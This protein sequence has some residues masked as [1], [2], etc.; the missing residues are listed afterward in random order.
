M[1]CARIG[2]IGKNTIN[3]AVCYSDG[4][5]VSSKTIPTQRRGILLPRPVQQRIEAFDR[6]FRQGAAGP[7]IDFSRPAGEPAL[8]TPESISWLVFKNPAAV[9]IGGVA[10][11]ILEL[12]EPRVRTGVWKHTSFRTAPL[13][14]L[15]R[16]GLAAMMTVYGPRR[17][18]EAMIAG[19]GRRHSAIVGTTLDG[20]RYRADDPELLTWVHATASFG[21]LEAYHVFARPVGLIDRDRYYAEGQDAARLYGAIGA[22]ASQ[23]AVDA[24]FEAMRPQ[25]EASPIVFEFLAI[26]QR[27][28][29]LPSP[30]RPI[31]R[32]FVKAA[33]EIT[34]AWLRERLGLD[35]RWHPRPWEKRLVA[36]ACQAAD[37]LVVRSSPAVQSCRR[38]GLPDDYLYRR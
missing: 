3:R 6:S 5:T 2:P 4:V 1:A 38:L 11:V 22:P 34:P 31:Q 13:E 10:A 23:A 35:E 18:A 7:A 16:T 26:M 21:F 27:M 24:I 32:L 25:L 9:F 17:Q 19:I 15:R 14:R 33:V 30:F 28:P 29:A 8:T 37:R 20:Q 12:A 36:L